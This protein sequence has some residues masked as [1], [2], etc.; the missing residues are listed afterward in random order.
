[1]HVLLPKRVMTLGCS[2]LRCR[3]SAVELPNTETHEHYSYG[4][5]TDYPSR[6]NGFKCNAR[7]RLTGL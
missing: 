7:V 3:G 5:P 6:N 4:Q 2:P 1:M